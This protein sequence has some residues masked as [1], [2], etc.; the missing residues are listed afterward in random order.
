[1]G[2]IVEGEVWG[3]IMRVKLKFDVLEA[4]T[5]SSCTQR[6]DFWEL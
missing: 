2:V 3:R 6:E 5:T 1:M 4:T